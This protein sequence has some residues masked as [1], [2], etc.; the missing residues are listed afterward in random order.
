MKRSWIINGL[1]LVLTMLLMAC[2]A[3]GGLRLL[4]VSS[5]LSAQEVNE[6]SPVFRYLPDR[7][8]VYSK[9]PMLRMSNSGHVNNDGFVNDNDYSPDRSAPLI[10][11]VGDSFV[12]ALMVRFPE[13]LSGK[14]TQ[15]FG[16]KA[17]VF[18]FAA[19]GAALSQYLVWADYAREKYHPDRLVVVI[20]GNDFDE[21]LL[22]YKQAP[23]FHYFNFEASG[24]AK[25][26]RVDLKP[27]TLRKLLR[28]SALVRYLVLNFNL[29]GLLSNPTSWLG[30][31]GNPEKFAG[32]VEALAS[33]ERVRLSSRA[34]QEFLFRLPDKSGLSPDKILF[35]V[36]GFRYPPN[37][38]LETKR[39]N[40]SFFGVMRGIFIT[41][42]QARGFGVVDMDA[43]FFPHYISSHSRYEFPIDGHWNPLAHHLAADSLFRRLTG[44]GN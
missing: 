34:V 3:E 39:R 25:L 21:S 16:D 36:D 30:A 9:G 24:E 10:A 40:S 6:T 35:V 23:G 33:D 1:L 41:E 29:G 17:K 26:V 5:G 19:S 38:A 37:D 32:N 43:V 8:F 44:N 15:T 31:S 11:V 18:S 27:T 2:I 42:A 22:T 20:V 12:E 7:D 13:T 4:P 14:L 28:R